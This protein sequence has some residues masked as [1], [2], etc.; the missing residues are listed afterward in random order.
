LVAR[1]DVLDLGVDSLDPDLLVFEGATTDAS[2]KI[3]EPLGAKLLENTEA[4]QRHT[5]FVL[6]LFALL[7]IRE[8]KPF[9][10]QKHLS[11]QVIMQLEH[12]TFGLEDDLSI[13]E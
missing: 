8:N 2:R 12:V 11:H 3:M 13:S 1:D 4:D 10:Q 6:A 5:R 7:G 9:S